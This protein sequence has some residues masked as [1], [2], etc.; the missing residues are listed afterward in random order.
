MQTVL[1]CHSPKRAPHAPQAPSKTSVP[2]TEGTWGPQPLFFESLAMAFLNTHGVRLHSSTCELGGYQWLVIAQ[3][4][5]RADA[6]RKVVCVAAA[7]LSWMCLDKYNGVAFPKNNSS[8]SWGAA[9]RMSWPHRSWKALGSTY[10]KEDS[11]KAKVDGEKVNLDAGKLHCS[12][13]SPDALKVFRS[14]AVAL[15]W[16]KI[17]P[18]TLESLLT[19]CP[20]QAAGCYCKATLRL[21]LTQQHHRAST[22]SQRGAEANLAAQTTSHLSSQGLMAVPSCSTAWQQTGHGERGKQRI[23]ER[24][25]GLGRE[26][27]LEQEL[28][29]TSGS[30]ILLFEPIAR[31]WLGQMRSVHASLL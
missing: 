31:S 19:R 24:R 2:R 13:Q 27:N 17:Y 21:S 16:K 15:F 22:I 7:L 29:R 10:F 25:L 4:A 1:T 30:Q 5:E 18:G 20:C 6:T 3:R 26:R 14:L 28:G 11:S 8:C 9:R 23:K 12:E